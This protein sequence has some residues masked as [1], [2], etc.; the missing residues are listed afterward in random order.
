MDSTDEELSY[1]VNHVFIPP[2]LPFKEEDDRRNKDS[3]LVRF[4]SSVAHEFRASLEQEDNQ[5]YKEIDRAW[6]TICCMLETTN[7]L[8]ASSRLDEE[9]VK[10]ALEQMKINGTYFKLTSK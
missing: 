5:S 8:H 9:Q 3:A 10:N 1:I 2:K 7:S 4:I 6:G